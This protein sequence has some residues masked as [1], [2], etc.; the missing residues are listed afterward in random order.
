MAR[1]PHRYRLT[2]AGVLNVWQYDEQ[3]FHFADG[4]LLLR[5][6]NGAGKSKTLEMLLP[7]VLDGDKARMNATGGQRSQLL[8]LMSDGASGT[9]TRIGYLWVELARVDPSGETHV[10]TCGIGLRAS[11][12]AKQVTTWQFTVPG[13]VPELC[14][15]DGTPLSTPRCKELV[16]SL[17]GS[18]FEAPRAYKEHVGRLLFGLEPQAYDD[19]LRLLYWLRQPQVGEDI[20]PARLVAMLDEALPALDDEAVRQV[21]EAFDDLAEHGERVE[22]LAAAAAAVEASAAIYRRYAATVV[23]ERAA[24]A[25]AAEKERAARA[26]AVGQESA[27]LEQVVAALETAETEQRAAG[28]RLAQAASRVQVLE[29]G[30]LARNQQVLREKQRRASDLTD[31]AARARDAADRATE[32][33]ENGRARVEQGA[34]ELAEQGRR[35]V[36]SAGEI[37]AGLRAC[38]LTGALP[39]GDDAVAL[40]EGLVEAVPAARHRVTTVRAAVSVVRDA[41]GPVE[42]S[43]RVRDAA[44]ERAAEAERREEQAAGSLADA[45]REVT[46]L[47]EAWSREA[48]S[49]V[50]ERS[51]LP[52]LDI[53]APT[54][55]AL[56]S[57]VEQARTVAAPVL[58]SLRTDESEAAARRVAAQALLRE[59]SVRHATVL[60]ET[61]PAPPEPALPRPGRDPLRGLP[62]WR[63]VDVRDGIEAAPIEA[64]LQAAGLLDA[65]VLADGSLLAA[66]ILDTVLV[67]TSPVAGPTLA[68]ALCPD[69][70]GGSPVSAQAVAGVLATIAL[71][72]RVDDAG[73]PPALG[74]DGSWRLGPLRGRADKPVAQYVGSAARIAER[75]RRL[76]AVEAEQASATLE[77]ESASEA[78]KAAAD[79]RTVLL[80]WLD[81]LPSSDA[82]RAA[83]VRRDERSA[84]HDRAQA[85]ATATSERLIAATAELARSVEALERLCAEHDLPADRDALEARGAALTDLDVRLEALRAE[86]TRLLAAARRLEEDGEAAERDADEA[87]RAD[88]EADTAER[89]ARDAVQES[90]ALLD[91]L[92][93]EVKQMQA[94]LDAAQQAQRQARG[95]RQRADQQVLELTGRRGE[96]RSQLA[97][98][99]QRLTEALPELTEQATRVAALRGVPG[100]LDAALARPLQE[101]DHAGLDG[102]PALPLPRAAVQLLTAWSEPRADRLADA[103]DVHAEVR[104]LAAGPAADAEPRVVPVGEALAVMARDPAGAEQPLALAAVRLADE[105]ARERELLTDRERTLFEEHLLGELGDKL[106]ARRAE[107]TDLVKGMNDLLADVKTSQGIR[108][109]LD[110]SLR[111]DAGQD[112]HDAVALLG[113]AHGSLTPEERTRLR[114]VLSALIAV[115]RDADPERGYTEHL[116]RALD[117]RRWS[118]FAVRLHRPGTTAWTTLTRRTPLSQGEQKVVCYLPLFAAAA[119]HFTSV[120]GAAPYAPRLILLD[121]AFPKIDV[122]THPL[123]F[124]LLVDLDLDFVLTSERLWGDH[125]TVPSLAIYEALRAP[126]ERGIA[127]YRYTWDGHALV[128][129]G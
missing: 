110:W 18:V 92:G 30:P 119:A 108:V 54:P 83:W 85:E 111:E 1:D 44:A 72:D 21:G 128:G 100:L 88:A 112:V 120:A 69:V 56:D 95:E 16:E 65:Q 78:E 118:A 42:Q 46:A 121:D 127:Q 38:G 15:P 20:D 70:P 14:E 24:A 74:R 58:L 129:E 17:G 98:A 107:A 90:S 67:A 27:A 33:A 75:A 68:D 31:V 97:A 93:V 99:E 103:N 117:Y 73:G 36:A 50:G 94:D 84:A 87:K 104:S 19:L 11:A 125:P 115:Q 32:R 109:R 53:P 113:R 102:L 60:A 47:A 114:D 91:T 61:D 123:L 39:A 29:S 7:F 25:L 63:L 34:L 89:D 124:G 86:A 12:N 122:R 80:G 79:E 13:A 5:G 106:R 40:G 6:T 45:A 57:L 105:A 35:M 52:E 43:T 28:E 71:L 8:W 116:A 10:V 64:A 51:D 26:R 3:V 9:G 62:L 96:A 48:F 4:R 76:A 82:L 126:G 59:L 22:K 66:D 77:R 49:W 101:S 23:Q 81:R 55:T 2:R 37:D 41:V